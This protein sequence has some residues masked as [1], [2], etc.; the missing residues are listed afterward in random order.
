MNEARLTE[1][2]R[3]TPLPGAEQAERRGREVVLA[4]FER[5]GDEEVASR[6]A[7]RRTLA[8]AALAGAVAALLGALVLSPAGASVRHWIG[9]VFTAGVPGAEPGLT[10]VPGGGKL[11]VGSRQGPWVVQPDGSRRLLGSYREGTWSPHGLYLGVVAGRTLTAVE[12][13]GTPR[14]SLT[15]AAPVAAPRWSPSGYRIAYRSGRELRA[16]VADGSDDH[17]VAAA[18]APVPPAWSPLGLPTLAYVGASGRLVVRNADSGAVLS[19]AAALPG[20]TGLEWAPGG[21]ALLEAS[22]RAVRLRAVHSVKLAAGVRLGPARRRLALPGG[23]VRQAALSPSGATIAVLLARPTSPPRDEVLLVDR[24][25]GA[26]RHLFGAPSRLGQIAWS[27]SGDK[28]LVTWPV[29]DQWLFFPTDGRGRVKAL[30]QVSRD[31]APGNSSRAFPTLEAWCC[32]R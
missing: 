1:L 3:E 26:V 15:A 20:I 23:R 10:R 31:F 17:R 11:L 13:D 28:L 9:D 27:P 30:G 8:R 19:S 2:L 14:W 4:A 32:R 18:V 21:D 24:R 16:V 7:P 22:P 12:P 5:R 6:P 25:D 29:A